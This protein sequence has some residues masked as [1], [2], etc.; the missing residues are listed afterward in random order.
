MPAFVLILTYVVLALAPLAL[1]AASGRP[2]RPVMDEIASAMAMV[3][4]AI[5]LVEFVLSGRFRSISG[6]VGLDVTMR[7]HQLF[8]RTALALALVHPFL[9]TLP[10]ARPLPFD[11]TRQLTLTFAA[12]GLVT[13]VLAFV[14]LPAFVLLSIARDR[15]GWRYETW[16]LA[17]GLGAL[18]IAL[19]VL[20]HAR[21]AGRYSADPLLSG[22]WAVLTAIAALSLLHV[23][24]VKP[25]L[26]LRRPWRVTGLRK[27]A[28]RTWEVVLSPSGHDGIAY[29]AGQ[30]AWIRIGAPAVSL[31]E[32]PF[33]IASAPGEG[34]DLRFVIKE[35]G[36][37]TAT[38]SGIPLGTTAYV[39]GPHGNLV[40][41]GRGGTGIACIAGGVGIAPM[42]GLLRQ[43]ELDADPRPT[44]LVYGNRHAGQIACTEDLAR[45]R[46]RHRTQVV[47]VLLEPPDDWQG[48]RGMVD[49]AL[50]ARLFAEPRHRDWLYVLCGPPA[51]METVEAALLGLGV[52]P[53]RI[54]SERFQ[55]D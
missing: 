26:A 28:E 36:D 37:F 46:R 35:L 32:N 30:F 17:H 1:A 4:F 27:L 18:V 23:Y 29:K 31:R 8:A 53:R 43:L 45:L 9:Y 21:H 24:V 5:L 49:A 38:L 48:E 14:L 39:D 3:A 13:G 12:E 52:A 6:R 40:L 11:P 2:P 54:I 20:I 25:L 7:F 33:S 50:V 19:L 42:L 10:F 34:R 44:V 16:R 41:E 55:H 51:M 22:L 47:Q 15:I